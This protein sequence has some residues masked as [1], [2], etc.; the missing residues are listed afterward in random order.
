MGEGEAFV[1]VFLIVEVIENFEGQFSGPDY[2]RVE[3]YYC[4]LYKP[5]C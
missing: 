4:P 5:D 3:A 2:L 1:P